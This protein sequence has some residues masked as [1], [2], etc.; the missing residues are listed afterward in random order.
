[1][2]KAYRPNHP[3][4]GFTLLEMLI[5]GSIGLALLGVIIQVIQGTRQSMS[6]SANSFQAIHLSGKIIS[7]LAEDARVEADFLG[8][9]QRFSEMGTKD[10]V[11]DGTSLYFRYFK[12][13]VAPYGTIDLPREGGIRKADGVTYEQ[14]KIFQ[15]QVL[16]KPQAPP[17]S[18]DWHRHIAESEI[19]LT[20]QEKDG[21]A[22]TYSIPILVSSPSGPRP[23]EGLEVNEARLQEA[24]VAFLFP[25][26]PGITFEKACQDHGCDLELARAVARLGVFS[27][28]G[29]A[30]LASLGAEIGD[31]TQ[32]A[33][34]RLAAPDLTLVE[35][36]RTTARRADSGA[37]LV[38]QVLVALLDDLAVIRRR[39]DASLLGP[40]PSTAWR[41][42]LDSYARLAANLHPWLE[43]A[44][45]SYEWL[46]QD[47]LQLLVSHH[48]REF[49]LFKTLDA[50]R[51][52]LALG[53]IDQVTMRA[54]I[55][56]GLSRNTGRNPYLERLFLR[57]K[58]TSLD[59][60]SLRRQFP[61]VDQIC[62]KMADPVQPFLRDIPTLVARHPSPVAACPPQ[63]TGGT[64]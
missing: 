33:Q 47:S 20:W 45:I 56:R 26:S 50:L 39:A 4:H 2:I 12:D 8:A 13:R 61:T 30:G 38:Y 35:L 28:S 11:V 10:G 37:S 36:Q 19:R 18:A 44:R 58:E 57:E 49:A 24:M 3:S 63:T 48:D 27:E 6:A 15:A 22:V 25:G 59:A 62:Q 64:Q 21:R 34:P 46:L 16:A 1:M 31:L 17:A 52:Q 42:A 29:L 23:L 40:I 32:R 53:K 5:A 41:K 9:Y 55:E 54:F 14:L 51:L 60:V 7:D 43:R